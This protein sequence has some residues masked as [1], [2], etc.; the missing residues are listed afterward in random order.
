MEPS[1]R[2]QRRRRKPRSRAWN[3]FWAAVFFV[4]GVIGLLIPVVPQ[5]PFFIMSVFFLSLVFPRVR[6]AMRRF[7]SR[8]PRV[9]A[10]YRKWRD[11]GRRKRREL[12]ARERAFAARMRRDA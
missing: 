7:L 6:R 11:R 8:H 4:L 9:N 10:S 1:E 2:P 5:I 12:I 3:L